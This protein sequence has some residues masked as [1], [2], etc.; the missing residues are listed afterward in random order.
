MTKRKKIFN[1]RKRISRPREE[2]LVLKSMAIGIRKAI[3]SPRKYLK[4]TRPEI[5][6]KKDYYK[7]LCSML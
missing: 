1:Q 3:S 2:E 5:N 4:V 7:H 6:F